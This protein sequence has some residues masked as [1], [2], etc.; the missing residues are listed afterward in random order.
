MIC[1]ICKID[2]LESEFHWRNKSKGR[3]HCR[4]KPCQKKYHSQYYNDNKENYLDKNNKRRD[5][6]RNKLLEILKNS[7][8]KVCEENHPA[9]L[10]FHHVRGAKRD[11]VSRLMAKNFSWDIIE[12]EIEKC[13]IVC[14]NCHRKITAKERN[15]Y[16]K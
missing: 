16:C 2:K 8:C 4:C 14:A 7:S 1:V 10:D 3:R 11:S 6:I 5:I 9:C 12:K 13:D 15:W